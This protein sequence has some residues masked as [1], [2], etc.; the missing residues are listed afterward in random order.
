[1]KSLTLKSYAKLNLCLEILD[2]L[3]DNYHSI[4][5]LFERINLFDEI[6][7]S[8][9]PRTKAIKITSSGHSMPLDRRNLVYKSASLLKKTFKIKEGI[10]INIKKN[11]PVGAGL[12]GGSSNAA[13]VL[14]GLNLFWNLKAT[15]R[16]LLNIAFQI[17]CDVSFF[18]QDCPF[19]YAL[20]KGEKLI[21]LDLPLSLWQVIV[22]PRFSLSTALIYKEWDRRKQEGLTLSPFTGKIL[23]NSL[24]KIVQD[25]YPEIRAIR[26]SF[27][28]LG[29]SL[30]SMSGSGPTMFGIVSS[31][32]EG[33]DI[34]RK[35]KQFNQ[36]NV[37]V[38]RSI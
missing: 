23:F 25:L 34:A 3:P 21:P 2:I 38:V 9:L 29:I 28:K 12:G 33:Y 10:E 20:G 19:A 32:K 31:R 11:I 18:L 14:Q 37:S 22:M 15:Q 27:Y 30:V 8:R 36:G 35:L 6:R 5:S 16:Q 13:T 24:E 26:K 7:L 1:M 4:F 17:G